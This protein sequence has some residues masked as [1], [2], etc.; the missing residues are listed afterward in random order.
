MRN[1]CEGEQS[2]GSFRTDPAVLRAG[3]T[4]SEHSSATGLNQRFNSDQSRAAT[5]TFKTDDSPVC[6][7]EHSSRDI[8]RTAGLH[9][10]PAV[11]R[12]FLYYSVER[13]YVEERRR[14]TASGR[15]TGCSPLR[16]FHF[17]Q[18]YFTGSAT[19][20]SRIK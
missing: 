17:S 3:Y 18:R 16:S 11:Y 14:G 1:G 2:Y 13:E 15:A 19:N 12:T 8:S 5:T 9:S 20:W 7:A 4:R 10:T 6:T